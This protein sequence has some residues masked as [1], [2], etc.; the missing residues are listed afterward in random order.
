[1]N[2]LTK[3]ALALPISLL[4]CAPLAT[5]A[6]ADTAPNTVIATDDTPDQAP[7]VAPAAVSRMVGIDAPIVNGLSITGAGGSRVTL[8]A[9]G[10]KTRTAK[11]AKNAAATFR[12]LTAGK[13]YTVVING[14]IVGTGTPVG[15]VG[16]ATGLTVATTSTPDE[17]LLRW[18]QRAAKGQG[19]AISYQVVAKPLA[20]LGRS[21]TPPA[22][23][24][25]TTTDR[26]ATIALDPNVRYT[27]TVTP[28]NS[29]SVGTP[30]A[31]TM[32][33]TLKEM[34]GAAEV[35]TTPVPPA[36]KESTPATP[37]TPAPAGPSTKT[38]Y[39]CPDT[40]TENGQGL[41]EKTQPYT[42]TTK[43][44]T[45]HDVATGP[46]P[47][48]D[49]IEVTAPGCAA[50]Y[51]YEDYNWIKYCRLYGPVPTIQVK[52]NSPAGYTDNGTQWITKDPAPRGYTDNGTEWIA[53]TA[54]V[55]KVVPA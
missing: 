34:G 3:L 20:T 26:A 42:F 44:Y 51:H 40:Y 54:K 29:A 24:T 33:R 19:T 10:E 27:F 22:E 43:A 4:I 32:A 31:A 25:G 41:C 11:P 55:A 2:T 47:I 15:P 16:P 21:T 18:N 12:N 36:P 14:T 52:D 28:R 46:A 45:F 5:P 35:P 23:V 13:A 49:Q 38:I 53:T 37:P 7:V 8:T 9:R 50:G 48:I 6:F 17:V 1:M 30:T 39:V